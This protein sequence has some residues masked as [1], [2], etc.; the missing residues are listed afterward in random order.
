MSA[1]H[2]QAMFD[3]LEYLGSLK[4]SN[5]IKIWSR[6]LEKTSAALN[7]ESG[8]Y[9]F[10]DTL[11]RQ[12]IPFYTVGGEMQAG[13]SKGSA[14]GDGIC[15][16]VAKYREPL[17]VPDVSKDERFHK[18]IDRSPGG[19]SRTVLGIPLFVQFDFVGVFE[20]FNKTGGPFDENDRR[21][22]QT[23]TQQACHA[24]RRL[25]LEDTVSRVTAYNAS[26]LE[27]LS[28]GFLA[29]D[30]QNRVMICNPAGRR[31]LD[32][33][34]EPLGHPAEEV[35]GAVIELAS[36]LRST[37][38]TKQTAKRQEL[39]WTL[40]GEKRVLGYSTLL[41]RDTQG[42]FAGAGVTFQDLTGLNK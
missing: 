9:Y 27:N 11:A 2:L 30:L 22:A 31:I 10:F 29:V 42:V 33:H 34:T 28:G 38:T 8:T 18:E 15:G 20:F 23:M 35:L 40:R 12:L 17:L 4:E 7:A 5:D 16:W 14:L 3:T 37:L 41:I 1:Q 25:R 32:I 6:M 24:I 26:I 39:H 19:E 36:V 21:L 13:G